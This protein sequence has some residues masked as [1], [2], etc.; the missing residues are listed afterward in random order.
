MA[1]TPKQDFQTPLRRA[2]G[3]GSAKEGTGHFIAQRATALCLIPLVI[4]FMASLVAFAGADYAAMRAYI[5][6]PI[7]TV[8]F[9]LL[10]F[11]AFYHM[12]LGLQVVIED[13][14]S[15][16]GT[17]IVLMLLT[18]ALAYGLGAAAIIAVLRVAFTG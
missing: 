6:N 10:I 1:G 7:V 3:L 9:V 12:K 11:A 2:R 8:L 5:A 15:R 16:E 14:I 17:R 18:T 13:Y 4:W